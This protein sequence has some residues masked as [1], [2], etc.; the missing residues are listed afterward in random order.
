MPKQMT[1][2]E[3]VST[4]IHDGATITVG[5]FANGLAHPEEVMEEL[6]IAAQAGLL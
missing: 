1:A 5:G 3:A 2:K 4:Y 6:G